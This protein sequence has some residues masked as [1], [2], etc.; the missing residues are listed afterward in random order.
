MALSTPGTR[1]PQH[2][3]QHCP[4]HTRADSHGPDSPTYFGR[5]SPSE[6]TLLW[7]RD[8]SHEDLN[9]AMLLVFRARDGHWLILLT[10]ADIMST[11][12]PQV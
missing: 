4:I 10:I 5:D 2:K 6:V 9:H 12:T 8:V 7:G 1:G 11:E 3:L